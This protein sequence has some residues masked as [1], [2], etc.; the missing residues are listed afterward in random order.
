MNYTIS[1]NNF[2]ALLG[3]S[4]ATVD[5]WIK[6]GKYKVH[7][8]NGRKVFYINE[9]SDVE[10]I[11]AML[12]THWQDE[13]HEAPLRDFTSVELF[14]GAG[15]L[16]LGMEKAGFKH[17]LL[18]EIDHSAC[19]TLRLNRPQWNVVEGD[20]HELDFS[21]LRGKVDFLS[22]GFPCQAFSYAGKRL[23]FEETRG[24]LFFELARAVKEI[25]PKVFMGENVRGLLEH[26]GGRTMQTIKDVIAE[27]GYTLIEPRVLRAIQYDVPQKRERLIIIAIRNDIAPLVEF[28]WPDV[29]NCVRTL[30]D[31]FYKGSLF[32]ADV[33]KSIGQQYPEKKRQVMELVPEGGDWRDLPEDVARDYMKGSYNLGGG[34]T[35]M[36]RRLSMDEPSLTLTCAPA[37]KQ[38]ER[39]HPLETR[40]LTVRE[41][42]R[43]Q[44]FPDNWKFAGTM[45]AQYKQI[46]NAVPINLA[47]AVGRSL[48]R[49]FN[50]M[51]RKGIFENSYSTEKVVP[52]RHL[53][54]LFEGMVCENQ[55]E[56]GK[57]KQTSLAK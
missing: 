8:V 44:T 13:K 15:G 33:P 14:A 38:T 9:L 22:G 36:A 35:G 18:N 55:V 46:G 37:Q 24:T 56:Y 31:A 11:S 42:A 40:P 51:V 20:I 16:A 30:H 3:V 6:K 34:K 2:A 53:H 26:D 49:L 27:L 12:S 1:I 41:Y 32:D 45:S 5:A 50:N 23:G 47:W 52:L 21:P 4:R 54:G 19:D 28:S 57:V 29:C 39:C 25:Q 48:I 43:I 10:E 17:V 7:E